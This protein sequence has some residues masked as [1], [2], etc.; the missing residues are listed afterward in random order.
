MSKV[1]KIEICF[2]TPVELPD[3]FERT[4]D[5]L[6]GMVCE[7]YQREH[8]TEVMWPAGYGSR[9]TFSRADAAFLGQ[10]ADPNAPDDGEPSWDASVY[11]ISVACRDD[12]YGDNPHNP[13]RERLRQEARA[14]RQ[15]R[16]AKTNG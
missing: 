16:K 10:K 7:Q 2:P 11:Q 4:L 3:G 5:A 15:Q 8:P 9:P 12:Y 14:D 6:I 13:D 1:S